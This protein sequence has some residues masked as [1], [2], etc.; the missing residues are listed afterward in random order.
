MVWAAIPQIE[1]SVGPRGFWVSRPVAGL[2]HAQW[3]AFA[4]LTFY[5][6]RR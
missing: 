4:A 3:V 2:P 6:F 1:V 5:P